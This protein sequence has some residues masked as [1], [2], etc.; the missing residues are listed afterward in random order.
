MKICRK[1]PDSHNL[2]FYVITVFRKKRDAIEGQTFLD[3]NT[4]GG[5]EETQELSSIL[6]LFDISE[7]RYLCNFL[8]QCNKPNLN[9]HLT[10]YRSENA[11]N[12]PEKLKIPVAEPT[13]KRDNIFMIQGDDYYD[14]LERKLNR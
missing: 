13:D 8:F 4:K 2:I 14:Q 12:E 5:N 7:Q 1:F 6:R 10:Y 9:F 11:E 3:F